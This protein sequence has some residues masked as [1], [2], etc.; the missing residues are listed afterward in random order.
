[1]IEIDASDRILDYQV[2][3]DGSVLVASDFA[4]KLFD[5]NGFLS[6]EFV[7]HYGAVR[8]V[9]VSADGKYLA[10]GG[11]DQSIILWK[12]AE[13]GYAPSLRKVFEGDDWGRILFVATGGFADER[14]DE[15]GMARC[16]G[17]SEEEW[18]QSI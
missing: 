4:L 17:F 8:A 18:K 11:E 7:G 2:L 3:Q 1:M 10:S 12:M 6:K 13:T 16:D 9:A 15:E 5:K 14:A